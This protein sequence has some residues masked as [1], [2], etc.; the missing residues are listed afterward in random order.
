LKIKPASAG[1]VSRNDIRYR[2][3]SAKQS[4]QTRRENQNDY[5]VRRGNIVKG[6]RINTSSTQMPKT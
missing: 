6:L 3:L 4:K 2:K 5:Q 1:I